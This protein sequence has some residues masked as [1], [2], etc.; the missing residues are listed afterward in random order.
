MSGAWD[1]DKY[2]FLNMVERTWEKRPDMD[3]YVFAEADTYIIWPNLVTWLREHAPR[4]ETYVGS[5]AMIN[6]HPFA[7]GGSG[8]VVSGAMMKKMVE[9]ISGI[10]AKYDERA[11]QEC[12]GD[13]LLSMAV[14]EAGGKVKQAHPMFNGEKPST[15]P[16]GPG[17]WC[18]P[19]IT[20]HHMNPEEVSMMWQYEQTR[21][22]K[23]VSS[24]GKR[25][26]SFSS[27]VS[28]RLTL[29]CLQEAIQIKDRY[30]AFMAPHVVPFRDAWDNLSDDVCYI[31]RDE[32][33]QKRAG[34]HEKARQK[35]EN[36]KNVVERHAH[37][38]PA[39]CAK[40]CEAA[41]LEIDEYE[42]ERIE[43]NVD[44]GMHIQARL[45]ER[46]HDESFKKNRTCFQWRYNRGACCVSRSFRLGRPRREDREEG[47][48]TSGW[49][50]SGVDDWVDAWAQCDK[51]DWKEVS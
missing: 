19:M 25:G 51:V 17:H 38:S 44:R 28:L 22:H 26:Y 20:M 2:K 1:L 18:E 50:L 41:G 29:P 49:F 27:K 23:T 30:Q 16:Y 42:Y 24:L 43:S 12:C 31:S 48:W 8:Y 36:E 47:T 7:H 6:N 15:L 46:R 9:N 45:N 32:E 4:G 3:W 40:V 33:A 39:T 34:D 5:V 35:P 21:T 11:T 14:E 37:E 10:A 13:L